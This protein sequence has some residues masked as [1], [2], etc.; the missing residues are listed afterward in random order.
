MIFRSDA[1]LKK[2]NHGLK[3]DRIRQRSQENLKEEEQYLADFGTSRKYT[4]PCNLGGKSGV[5]VSTVGNL[6]R[7]GGRV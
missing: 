2:L 3:E 5:R 6:G 1:T 7:I 4:L